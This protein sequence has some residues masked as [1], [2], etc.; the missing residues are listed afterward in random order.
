MG[1]PFTSYTEVR[2][3]MAEV[4]MQRRDS[5]WF[6]PIES[7]TNA[8]L[9]SRRFSNIVFASNLQIKNHEQSSSYNLNFQDYILRIK[10]LK[11]VNLQVENSS[12]WHYYIYVFNIN[13]VYCDSYISKKS[14]HLLHIFIEFALFNKKN[15][16]YTSHSITKKSVISLSITKHI[17]NP[18]LKNSRT[19]F[20]PRKRFQQHAFTGKYI[21]NQRT[22]ERVNLQVENSI[23]HDT[24][25]FYCHSYIS[26]KTSSSSHFHSF[27]HYLVSAC[28][29]HGLNKKNSNPTSH[30]IKINL[31]KKSRNSSTPT[32]KTS[33]NE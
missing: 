1:L 8:T 22:I 2:L 4:S 18:N 27:L 25:L 16:N 13:S 20:I 15:I 21:K 23:S 26:K 7:P 6:L 33:K 24:F 28:K 29:I 31:R 10:Q 14:P 17:K 5:H 19:C 3:G 12:L 30:S 32:R 9:L 11:R